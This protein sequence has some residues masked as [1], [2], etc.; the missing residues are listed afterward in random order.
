VRAAIVGAGVAGLVAARQL[1]LAGWR[2][3][4]YERSPGPNPSGYMMDFFGPGFDA[5]E[6]IGVLS[7]LKEVSYRVDSV[8]YVDSVEHVDSAWRTT[9]RLDYGQFYRVLGGRLLSLLRPDLEGVLLTALDD[10]REGRGQVHFGRRVGAA[11]Q[12]I[13][14]GADLVLGADGIHSAV[15]RA[16]R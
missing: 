1:G 11:G 12:P 3:D 4:V 5:A 8:E 6:R 13:P 2:V 15:R 7:R 16:V 14:D 10:V 9:A